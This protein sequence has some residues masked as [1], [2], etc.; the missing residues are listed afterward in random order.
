MASYPGVGPRI[1]EQMV[2]RGYVRADGQ[3]DVQRFCWDFRYDRTLVYA[4]LAEKATPF[5]DLIRLT[6]DLQVSAEWLLTG[7]DRE[8]RPKAPRR[9]GRR[10]AGLWIGLTLGAATGLWPSGG[11][12]ATPR[13][14]PVAYLVEKIVAYRTWRQRR[15]T[16]M[17]RSLLP[18]GYPA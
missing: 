15:V 8:P 5:K 14:P 9:Q 2:K 11:V 18:L 13:T 16:W 6:R 17:V 1:R 3:P 7:H 4:W 12:A 10:T